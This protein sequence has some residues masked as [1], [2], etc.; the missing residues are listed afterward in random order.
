MIS[1]DL[2]APRM[3]AAANEHYYKQPTEAH[4][5]DR[6]LEYHDLI[7][8][9]EGTW[10]MTE[11]E[12]EYPLE[13]GD[14]LFLAAG[15]H[16]YNRLPCLPE[17]RTFCL[18]VTTAPGDRE[19]NPA[20]SALPTHLHVRHSEQIRLYFSELVTAWWS[21]DAFREERIRA[22]LTLL[23]LEI[24][25]EYEK[26]QAGTG[27]LADR[28]IAL[29]NLSPHRRFETSKMAELL[30]VSTRTLNNAMHKKTGTS[31][32]AYEKDLKLERIALQLRMEPEIKISEIA[33]SYGF[34][35]E[36]HLSKAFKQKFGMPPGEY[37]ERET[38]R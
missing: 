3:L 33:A 11:G 37:R 19:D 1:V 16:H 14:V 8:I 9:E 28:A 34:H 21:D 2:R 24:R 35:D 26:Q 38:N 10:T 17:T 12:E 22:L 6:V 31:F 13:K 4:Y 15:R 27:D 5:L 30:F 7:Y 36:F 29:L 18:H 25:T 32:Y 20:A 23:L